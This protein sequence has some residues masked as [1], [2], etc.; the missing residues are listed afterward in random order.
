MT[1]ALYTGNQGILEATVRDTNY[2]MRDTL[3]SLNIPVYFKDYSNGALIGS[4]CKGGH[5]FLCWNA[6]LTDV[7][8]RMMAVLQQKY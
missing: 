1:L 7:L 4:G 6:A 3:R 8:P 5:D 2:R